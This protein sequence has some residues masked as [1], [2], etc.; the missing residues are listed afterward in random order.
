MATLP[1][2][3]N[4]PRYKAIDVF[5]GIACLMVVIHHSGFAVLDA[6]TYGSGMGLR[7]PIVAF[8]HTAIG[9]PMFFVISGYCAL[10][11]MDAIRRRGTSP[12]RFLTKRLWRTY[13][14]YWVALLGFVA[15]VLGLDQLGLERIYHGLYALELYKPATL[16]LWQW[17]GNITLTEGLRP[18]VGGSYELVFT[19][20]AWTL[21]FQ[22]QFYLVCFL[23]L[24]LA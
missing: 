14:P 22:E 10:A 4:N 19:R 18:R 2:L 21:C 5:R 20:V 24:L 6:D 15:I 3:R 8:V 7:R 17:L 23:T 9:T 12:W 13:P 16:D 1:P 11:S